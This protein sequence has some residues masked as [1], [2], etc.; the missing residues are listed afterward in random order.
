MTHARKAHEVIGAPPVQMVNKTYMSCYRDKLFSP[1][2][3]KFR[4]KNIEP[5]EDANAYNPVATFCIHALPRLVRTKGE[6][7]TKMNAEP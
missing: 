5:V 4:A 7:P 2:S 1:S 6:N 3:P